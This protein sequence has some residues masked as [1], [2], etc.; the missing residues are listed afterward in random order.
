M[1]LVLIAVLLFTTH[2]FAVEPLNI[3]PVPR[4]V[5]G[6][7]ANDPSAP[8]RR[9]V[10][11]KLDDADPLFIHDETVYFNGVAVGRMTSGSFGHTLGS[12]VGLA[13]V[14]PATDLA[15]TFE[16]QCKGQLY[17]ATVS[18]RPFY[19]PKGERLCG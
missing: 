8:Q 2:F 9:T 1:L 10:Y 17:P 11:V 3:P 6:L 16:V 18:R 14:D 7:I 5:F 12:A 13:F 15:G 19:D 4:T